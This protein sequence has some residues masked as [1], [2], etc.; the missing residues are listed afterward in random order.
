MT[1]ETKLA[2]PSTHQ[3]GPTFML[4]SPLLPSPSPLHPSP[5]TSSGGLQGYDRPTGIFVNP[6]GLPMTFAFLPDEDGLLSG[7]VEAIIVSHE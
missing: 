1:P 6:S 4:H 3:W 7:L 2:S 5:A